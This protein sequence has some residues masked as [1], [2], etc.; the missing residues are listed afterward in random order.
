MSEPAIPELVLVAHQLEINNTWVPL[1][2]L[3]IE[4]IK[5][6]PADTLEHMGKRDELTRRLETLTDRVERHTRAMA[7]APER[8]PE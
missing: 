6:I 7:G 3:C 4:A 8:T 1:A 5:A 2:R